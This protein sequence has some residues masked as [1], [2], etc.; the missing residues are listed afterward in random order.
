MKADTIVLDGEMELVHTLDG[1]LDVALGFNGLPFETGQITVDTDTKGGG[2]VIDFKNKHKDPPF[3]AG[4]V[5]VTGTFDSALDTLYSD[6]VWNFNS[7]FNNVIKYNENVDIVATY[8]HVY[9][10]SNSA[11]SN[12]WSISANAELRAS[13]ITNEWWKPGSGMYYFRQNRIYKW[14]AVWM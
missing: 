14:I 11:L 9:R 10:S 1:E 7:A 3:F 6:S 4:I 8:Y 5:D 13:F 2:V 12:S